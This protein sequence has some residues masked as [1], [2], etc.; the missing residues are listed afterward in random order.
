MYEA[1][2]AAIRR[3]L[4]EGNLICIFPEGR[5]TQDGEIDAFRTGIERIIAET[6]VPVI[7]MALQGLW[8]S[9]FSHHGDGAF[10]FKGRFW[11]KIKLVAGAP[12]HPSAVSASYLETLVRALRGT[13]R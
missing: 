2:F 4:S 13:L 6:P 8:G 3:E 11:S 10:K 1:A 9:F 12:V 5:L 7:P